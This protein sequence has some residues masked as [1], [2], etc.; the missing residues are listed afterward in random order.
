MYL[1]LFG[2]HLH[3]YIFNTIINSFQAS[4]IFKFNIFKK[5]DI[6][7]YIIYFKLLI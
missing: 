1:Y 3:P 4:D 5:L 2:Q 6:Y 7:I